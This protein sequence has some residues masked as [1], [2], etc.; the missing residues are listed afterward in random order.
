VINL[1]E[2]ESYDLEN[3]NGELT[4][5]KIRKT[6][7]RFLRSFNQKYN[8]VIHI[9]KSNIRTEYFRTLI[10]RII[11]IDNRTKWNSWYNIFLILL[12]LKGKI[13]EYCEKYKIEFKK[14]FLSREDWKKLNIIKNFLIPFLR[15]TLITEENSVSINRTLFNMDIL[16]KYLQETIVRFLSSL[17]LPS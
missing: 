1:D 12:Q 15:A 2:L 6:R 16:I 8:I 3:E 4:D 10:E 11:P 7:F 9:R 13:E 17:L 5:K 14:D